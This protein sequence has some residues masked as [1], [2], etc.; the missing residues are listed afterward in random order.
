MKKILYFIL[1]LFV[2]CKKDERITNISSEVVQ[3]KIDN[4][5]RQ[6]QKNIKYGFDLVKVDSIKFNDNKL[7]FQVV[8]A[9]S[10]KIT[11]I[12][13]IIELTKNLA[14]IK[15]TS[16]EN[17]NN[18]K[19]YYLEK[20]TLKS[21]EVIFCNNSGECEIVG[22]N[23][24]EKIIISECGH[25]SDDCYNLITG[26]NTYQV[27]NPEYILESPNKK[28]RLN[29]Y[30]PGQE[31]SNYFIQKKV[32]DEYLKIF[33]INEVYPFKNVPENFCIMENLFWS[34]DFTLNFTIKNYKNN[35][36]GINDYYQLKI[37]EL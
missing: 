35:G 3:K 29:G 5:E 34:N 12:N 10:K 8:K 32:N 17:Q 37:K 30:F 9:K 20:I 36:K 1:I 16:T 24:D 6:V 28:F 15:S 19:I 18:E 33:E 25:N 13:L 21:G 7:K 26:K 4:T 27:G 11:D 2:Q 22:Y 23:P 14:T 31:C